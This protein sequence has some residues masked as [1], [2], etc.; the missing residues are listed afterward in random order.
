VFVVVLTVGCVEQQRPDVACEEMRL[1]RFQS[2]VCADSR[3][4]NDV[5][6]EVTDPA[7]KANPENDAVC[8]AF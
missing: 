4:L 2:L 5:V 3:L 8:I 6:V 1:K 7:A